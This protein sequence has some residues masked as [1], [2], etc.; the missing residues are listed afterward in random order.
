MEIKKNKKRNC[1]LKRWFPIKKNN[2]T[3]NWKFKLI[4]K[5]KNSKGKSSLEEKL[6]IGNP[7]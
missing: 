5:K 7:N 1:L 6:E 4:L 3:K 2:I